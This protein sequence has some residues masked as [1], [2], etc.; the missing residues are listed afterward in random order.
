MIC[1][2]NKLE[3]REVYVNNEKLRKAIKMTDFKKHCLLIKITKD[4]Q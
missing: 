1:C 4:F 3:R 2:E